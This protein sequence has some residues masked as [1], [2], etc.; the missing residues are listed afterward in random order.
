M[1]TTPRILLVDDNPVNLK[2]ARMLLEKE[3]VQVDTVADGETAVEAVRKNSYQ[4]VLMDVQLPGIDGLEATRRIRQWEEETQLRQDRKGMRI[5]ALTGQERGEDK[6]A[7]LEAG[8]DEVMEKPL[9]P[10]KICR[11]LAHTDRGAGDG[12]N[13]PS[14]LLDL[15][16]KAHGSTS[17]GDTET[18]IR[19]LLLFT[20]GKETYAFDL[21]YMTSIR[22]ARDI[23]PVPGTPSHILGIIHVQGDIISVVDLKALLGIEAA[24]SPLASIVVSSTKGIDVGFLVDSV[25]DIIDLPLKSID[26]PMI[27]FEKEYSEVIDGEAWLDEKL[28]VI[29]NYE[30]IMASEKMNVHRK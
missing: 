6:Q 17:D 14:R 5:F 7:C 12:E 13:L 25:D 15:L 24:T 23:T 3:G 22:W 8:M 10:E 21:K 4:M 20:L 26:P 11:A 18:D 16:E 1:S 28:M 29:L 9:R 30:K 19:H 27:T 2:M